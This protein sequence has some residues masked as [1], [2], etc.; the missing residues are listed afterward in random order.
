MYGL[1]DMAMH[2]I[3]GNP[4]KRALISYFHRFNN[5]GLNPLML[6]CKHGQV[7][8]AKLLLYGYKMSDKTVS[9]NPEKL[10]ARD[11]LPLEYVEEVF[12][13]IIAKERRFRKTVA[14]VDEF[15]N[16]LAR[17]PFQAATSRNFHQD[18]S[19]SPVFRN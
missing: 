4:P 2:Y 16:K 1:Q 3:N 17:Y 12:G 10:R 13:S 11:L 8:M 18:S 6:A 5:E 14:E 15:F 7:A 9:N 19:S